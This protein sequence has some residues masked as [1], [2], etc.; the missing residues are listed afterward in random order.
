[1]SGTCTVL[2]IDESASFPALGRQGNLLNG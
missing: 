2:G 1:L